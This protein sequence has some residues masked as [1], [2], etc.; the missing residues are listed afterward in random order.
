MQSTFGLPRTFCERCVAKIKLCSTFKK[1]S[2]KSE[3][4]LKSFVLKISQ[5]FTKSLPS[6]STANHND[7]EGP[8][9]E[10]PEIEQLLFA[11]K[12]Y[13]QPET[14]VDFA[15]QNICESREA[16]SKFTSKVSVNSSPEKSSELI[17]RKTEKPKKPLLKAEK[18]RESK[19]CLVETEISEKDHKEE[20][21]DIDSSAFENEEQLDENGIFGEE[22]YDIIEGTEGSDEGWN[23][24]GDDDAE[25]ILVNFKSS[26]EDL[27]DKDQQFVV[28]ELYDDEGNESK[29]APVRKKHVNRMPREII[30]KYA[31][32]TDNNQ[33]MYKK[34]PK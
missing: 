24:A 22:I 18:Q 11:E 4:Y 30:E 34:V 27:T 14:S 15:H 25:F 1:D 21:M 13:Q 33:H 5:E 19:P 10:D 23:E 8:E 31:Q 2:L 12:Q 28:E 9:N 17:L 20:Y 32:S 29:A 16:E 3:N 6:V 7:T 26:N